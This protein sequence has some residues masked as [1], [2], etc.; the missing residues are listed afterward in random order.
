MRNT[1]TIGSFILQ[2]HVQIE[3]LYPE[4][5]LPQIAQTSHLVLERCYSPVHLPAEEQLLTDLLVEL[6]RPYNTLIRKQKLQRLLEIFKG[7]LDRERGREQLKMG[8][9][10]KAISSK[11]HRVSNWLEPKHGNK[12]ATSK[13]ITGFASVGLIQYLVLCFSPRARQKL[14]DESIAAQ[15]SRLKMRDVDFEHHIAQSNPNSHQHHF[16]ANWAQ[17]KIELIKYDVKMKAIKT[18]QKEKQ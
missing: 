12:A 16:W 15:W 8:E 7:L 10:L 6:G 14:Y 9:Q 3:E 11:T 1:P 2:L 18:R 5:T 13:T 17:N 4:A